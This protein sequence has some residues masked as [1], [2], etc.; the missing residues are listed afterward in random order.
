MSHQRLF[1]WAAAGVLLAAGLIAADDKIPHVGPAGEIKKMEG[2][3][4][5]T[6]GPAAD[7]VTV[8]VHP[9]Q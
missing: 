3:Y 7:A 2:T 8:L 4:S 9:W 5:F 6:E 1:G